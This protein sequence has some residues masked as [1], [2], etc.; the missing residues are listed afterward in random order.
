MNRRRAGEMTKRPAAAERVI[1]AAI[2]W[3]RSHIKEPY[4]HRVDCLLFQAVAA[5]HRARA[6]GK[7]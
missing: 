5:L 2:N 1:R 4:G 7:K 3:H 6:R